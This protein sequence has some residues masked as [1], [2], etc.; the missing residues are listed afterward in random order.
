MP[1]DSRAR[2]NISWAGVVE[3]LEQDLKKCISPRLE[4]GRFGIS[5]RTKSALL[6]TN[7]QTVEVYV[8]VEDAWFPARIRGKVRRSDGWHYA[9][10]VNHDDWDKHVPRECIRPVRSYSI[11]RDKA[12]IRS[13]GKRRFR[14]IF[15]SSRKR[16]KKDTSKSSSRSGANAPQSLFKRSASMKNFLDVSDENI[17]SDD[18]D[19][20][21]GSPDEAAMLE[22]YNEMLFKKMRNIDNPHTPRVRNSLSLRSTATSMS[23]SP[24]YAESSSMST[25]PSSYVIS[26]ADEVAI[27]RQPSSRPRSR[28]GSFSRSNSRAQTPRRKRRK[29]K[30]RKE[31]HCSTCTM[32]FLVIGAVAGILAVL[33]VLHFKMNIF[34]LN[35]EQPAPKRPEVTNHS[36]RKQHAKRASE[37]RTGRRLWE[38][39]T[40]DPPQRCLT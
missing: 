20:A 27:A 29:K 11:F 39:I 31:E 21:A 26:V 3:I 37:T 6:F 17:T 38:I 34:G 35:A 22:H 2:P 8:A 10:R 12:L 24:V 16:N 32:L 30:R 28:R 33:W 15:E 7:G 1:A 5:G 40:L 13:I 36:N 19:S 25:K 4:S 18:L 14:G 23:V 9:L